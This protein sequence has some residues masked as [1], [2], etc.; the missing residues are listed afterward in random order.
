MDNLHI[1]KDIFIGG[2]GRDGSKTCINDFVKKGGADSKPSSCE[3]DDLR[4]EHLCR[5]NFL[6]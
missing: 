3:C 4:E 1:R 6:C 5:C 2:C